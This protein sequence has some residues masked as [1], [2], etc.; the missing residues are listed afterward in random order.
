VREQFEPVMAKKNFN[1]DDVEA[2][3]EYVRSYVDFIHY[4]ERLY[5]AAEKPVPGYFPEAEAAEEH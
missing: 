1:K 4:V 5:E 2:G 3:R